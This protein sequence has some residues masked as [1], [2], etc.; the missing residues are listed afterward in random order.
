[1]LV[2]GNGSYISAVD[3]LKPFNPTMIV[4]FDKAANACSLISDRHYLCNVVTA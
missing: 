4:A 3:F 2:S 1:M